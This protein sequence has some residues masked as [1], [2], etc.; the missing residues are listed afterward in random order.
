[1]KRIT[2]RAGFLGILVLL[3]AA[4]CRAD[5]QV[6]TYQP[7]RQDRFYVGADKNFVGQAFDWS[8]VG[9]AGNGTW[10]TM[11]SPDYFLS[12]AHYHPSGGDILTFYANNDPN[13]PSYQ[14]TVSGTAY[15]QT[16]YSGIPSDLWLGKLTTPIP[17]ADHIAYYPVPQLGSDSNYIGQMIYVN[18]K[19]NRV[20]RNN[21]DTIRV[22]SEPEVGTHN[23]STV[24]MEFNYDTV[25]GLGAD[26]CF[27]IGGDSGGPSFM[28]VNGQL[29]VVGIHYYDYGT[30]DVMDWGMISGDS[31]VPYY[32]SQL[33]ANMGGESVTTVV[34]EPASLVL[35]A[36]AG[37]AGLFFYRR[38]R[39]AQSGC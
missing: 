33:N 13:G 27:L 37:L 39:A 32:V 6:Q 14:F 11:I 3:S 9:Q 15:F 19:P 20:G 38:R 1:M 22:A 28:D 24:S 34:P 31:F 36:A 30:P 8:G 12:A 26:E 23:K 7:N 21:I 2:K 29:A 10:A 17:A 16:S 4:V 35:L 5:M 18:G 25:G